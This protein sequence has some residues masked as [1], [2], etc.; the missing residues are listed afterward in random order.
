MSGSSALEVPPR[1]PPDQDSA[2]IRWRKSDRWPNSRRAPIVSAELLLIV[3]RESDDGSRAAR[4]AGHRRAP[5]R[6]DPGAVRR[7]AAVATSARSL[8]TKSAPACRHNSAI[9]LAS[10]NAA[11][12]K[13]LLV[14]VLE[15]ARRPHLAAASAV[16]TGWRRSD[17]TP[18]AEAVHAVRRVASAIAPHSTLSSP[19]SAGTT[20]MRARDQAVIWL[21]QLRAQ[22]HEQAHRPPSRCRRRSRCAPGSAA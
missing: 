17:R 21:P 9:L 8:M 20:S 2:S 6:P 12:E 22:R 1:P 7:S 11:R 18:A 15:D 5:D 14:P 4:F 16:R 13:E 10:S 19:S 3:R